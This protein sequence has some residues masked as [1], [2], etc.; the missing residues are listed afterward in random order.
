MRRGGT[1]ARGAAGAAGAGGPA[2]TGPQGVPMNGCN[3][4]FTGRATR[5]EGGE[6]SLLAGQP[7]LT[8]ATRD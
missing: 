5:D 4:R 8:A 3:T 6:Q 2:T 7:L 1:G